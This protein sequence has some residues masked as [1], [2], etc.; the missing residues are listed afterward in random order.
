M[1]SNAQYGVLLV[2][3]GTPDAPTAAAV[4][5]YLAEFLHD[6]RVV[7]L[8]RWIWCPV[9]HGIILRVRPPR[10]AKLYQSV[11]TEQGSP[12]MAISREQADS[13][14][15]KLSSHTDPSTEFCVELAMT[16]GNPSIKHGLSRLKEKGCQNIIILPLYPQY[17]SATSASVF[18]RVAKALNEEWDVP[19]IRFIR[20]YYDHAKYIDAL[21]ASISEH[22]QNNPRPD[23]LLMSFHGIPKRYAN[24]GDPYPEQCRATAEL[25]AKKLGLNDDQWLLTFQSRFGREEWLMPYTDKTLEKLAQEG[26][27]SVQ[28]VCPG[29]AADCLETLE[30]IESENK[31]IFMEHGGES[32][33]YIPC[34]NNRDDHIELLADL[35]VNTAS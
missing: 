27:R 8:T 24:N 17:S 21:A 33:G 29:F 2:N 13:L 35:V 10:V 1:P 11:W 28:I 19:S 15:Q 18:D 23:K 20:D 26:S 9:L 22:W 7:N 12:L 30:E 31:E 16:Y 14:Q 25:V 3:L 32:F 34:L 5:K 6:K 4:R